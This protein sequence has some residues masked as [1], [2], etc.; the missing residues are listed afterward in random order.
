MAKLQIK[1]SP[2]ELEYL[3]LLA[4]EILHSDER[5]VT[6]RDKKAKTI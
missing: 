2:A 5:E 6:S 4:T 1:F 3:R